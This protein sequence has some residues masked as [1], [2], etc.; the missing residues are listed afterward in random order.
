MADREDAIQIDNISKSFGETQAVKEL[1]LNIQVG[2]I[3]GILGP[4]GSGKSTTMK[5]IMGLLKPDKGS[6]KV[7]GLDPKVDPYKV[8]KII[9]YV[10]ESPHLYEFLTATEY[11]DFIA[12]VHEVDQNEYQ[13]KVNEFLEAFELTGH[14]NEVL[15]GYSHGM[16][17]K[18]AIIAA[19]LAE[20]RLLVLD[21]PLG[22]LDP[23]SARIMKDLLNKLTDEGVTVLFSTHVLEIAEAVCDQIGILYKGKLLAEGTSTEIKG[24]SN[25]PEGT[26]EEAFLKLT[27]SSDVREIVE[28]LAR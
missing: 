16:K 20:P 3:Y 19:L 25:T 9:G 4:N 6:I 26:L 14:E 13:F 24:L 7:Y 27:D 17:Q 22:G 10:P 28:E 8:K 11:L 18:I 21:E 2:T 5:M 1:T 15:G 23:R 12:I